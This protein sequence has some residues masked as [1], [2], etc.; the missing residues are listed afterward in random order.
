LL[1]NIFHKF[2]SIYM[3]IFVSNHNRKIII[4]INCEIFIIRS[5]DWGG[6]IVT[7]FIAS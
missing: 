3:T 1:V 2:R 7:R 4:R 5:D 6:C